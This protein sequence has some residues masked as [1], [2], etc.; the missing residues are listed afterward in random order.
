MDKKLDM[1]QRYALIA[2]KV[3]NILGCIKRAEASR[4]REGIVPLCSHEATSGVLCPGLRHP[5]WEGCTA[6]GSG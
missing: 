2:Q 4:K 1:S 3:N 6:A 5:V